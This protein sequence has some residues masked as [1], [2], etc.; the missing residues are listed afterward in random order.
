MKKVFY[1]LPVIFLLVLFASCTQENE[2]QLVQRLEGIFYDESF[3]QVPDKEFNVADYGAVADEKTLATE[4]IQKTID[5]AAEAGGGKVIFPTGTYLSG[6]LFVKSNVELNIGEGVVIQ[7]IQDNDHYPRL[8]TRIAGIEMK[9]PAALINVYD[10]SNVRITGKGV[11]DGNGKYWW[12]KFWGDPKYTGGMWGEYKEKGIR[13]AV[14][15]D[16]ERVRPVVIWESEDVLLKDFT[17]KRAGFWTVSLTYSTRV[18]VDGVVVR[19]NI[20]GHGPSSDGIDTDSS[21]DILVENCDIDCNDD[22][23]CIKA[24]KDADGLRVNQPAEN[25]VYRNCIT[26]AGHGLI[27]LGSETSGGMRNIEVYGLEAIG[28]NIGIR[29]KSAKVRGGVIENI[30][31]HDMKMK[32][33]ANPFHFELNWYP[34]YSYC[35]IPVN[36]PEEEIKDRWRVLSQRVEPEEKGIPEFKNISLSNIK[37]ENAQRA[38]YANAY[39]EKPIHDIHWKDVSVEAK[40]SGKLTYASNWTM[41][42]VLLKTETG[43]PIELQDCENIEQPEIVKTSESQP[44]EQEELSLDQQMGAINRN[45]DAVIIPVN[46]EA[47][48]ALTN[49]DTTD[50]SE[51]MNIYILKAENATLSYYEPL[52]DGFYQTPVEVSV[53]NVGA[54]FEIKGQ[55]EHVYS[56]IVSRDEKPENVTGADDWEFNADQK[57]VLIQKKGKSFKIQIN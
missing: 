1:S 11:I 50:F 26:R 3:A 52:G 5:A 36:I 48:Q 12:D 44:Q 32:D 31:F 51:T 39:P 10:E 17:V 13:W 18:H 23:L 15:Y 38:F 46:P 9:W 27:T 41:E 54:T 55:K 56:F 7:A 29:F 30:S 20:G 2:S 4:G 35:T 45:A 22:N 28:T 14:D 8:W 42:N 34:E 49:G 57:K 40:E 24:G 21:K 37:V 43:R 47:N 25:I 16:C 33:V 53:I 6:A 19:N